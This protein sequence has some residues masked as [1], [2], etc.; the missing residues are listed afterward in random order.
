[1]IGPEYAHAEAIKSHVIDGIV[2]RN[3]EGKN[4]NWKRR[5]HRKN[6]AITCSGLSINDLIGG[7]ILQ[8]ARSFKSVLFSFTKREGNQVAHQL[9]KLVLE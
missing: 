7:D 8:V 2:M 1:M 9:A 3:P 5:Y 4:Q 6:L